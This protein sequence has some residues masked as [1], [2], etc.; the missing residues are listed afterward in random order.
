MEMIEQYKQKIK[1]LEEENQRL[2]M[3]L[4]LPLKYGNSNVSEG[5]VY[6]SNSESRIIQRNITDQLANFFFSMFWGRKDAYAV[7]VV[8]KTSG[9]AAYYTQCVN[10]YKS[11]CYR[12]DHLTTPC[13]QCRMLQYKPLSLQ[14]IKDHLNGVSADGG[15]TV[16]IYPLFDDGT[17]RFIVFDFDDHNSDS[18]GLNDHLKAEV[19]ALRE[20]CQQQ[21]FEPIVERSR[22]GKGAHVWLLFKE[23]IEA[24]LARQ[25]GYGLLNA[26]L[27]Y[28]S[29]QHFNYFDLMLPKQDYVDKLGNLIALPLQG[30]ALKQ[31]NSAF[32][33]SEWNV[34]TDQWLYLS[35]VKK[36]DKQTI[37][38]KL[39]QWNGQAINQ[40]KNNAIFDKPWV[41]DKEFNRSDVKGNL[42]VVYKMG[43]ILIN[44]I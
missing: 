40:T 32:V 36:I 28:V 1:E 43:Y 16:G 41:R 33:D 10:F 22:S 25:F 35:N 39:K 44:Q 24:S 27:D 14:R 9:K 12:K 2:R 8:N 13:S 21:G 5:N 42:H 4:N 31:G 17:C 37:L 18:Q 11:G 7:R 38:T 23:P 6:D 19:N 3:L 29:L 30:N 26:G 34:Y 15:D 20:I